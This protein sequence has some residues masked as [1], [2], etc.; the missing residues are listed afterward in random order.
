MSFITLFGSKNTV[1]P[2]TRVKCDPAR[3]G[4]KVNRP[5]VTGSTGASVEYCIAESRAR[6]LV[7]STV[8]DTVKGEAIIVLERQ[9]ERER[10]GGHIY[11]STGTRDDIP[12]CLY[13]LEHR[14]PTG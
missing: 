14:E 11:T 10:G 13:E 12:G 6:P 9:R 7:L 3:A 5:I 1:S 8:R 2:A 4:S